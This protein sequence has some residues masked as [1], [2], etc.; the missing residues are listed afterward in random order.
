MKVSKE[1]AEENRER[2]LG[3]AARLFRERGLT[4]VGVDA[5]TH[6]AGLTHGS[7]YSQFGSKDGLMAEA[8][9]HGHARNV[10][11]AA[12]IKSVAD[13]VAMYLS[14]QHRDNPGTGCFMAALACEMPRQSQEVRRRFTQ[15][16]RNNVARFAAMLP[17]RRKR[18]R[19]DD[20]MAL[21]ATMVGG[22]VLARAVDDPD[23]S[24]RILEA[25][26]SACR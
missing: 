22:L 24:D 26:Q 19:E 7:L 14:A 1:K 10:T 11:R 4:G 18:E 3:E 9:S 2:I 16:V 6:A 15:I 8:L 23:F 25:A 20:A 13:A 5:L 21:I 17:A 12:N